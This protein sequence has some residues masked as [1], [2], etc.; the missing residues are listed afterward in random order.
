MLSFAH[1]RGLRLDH[2]LLSPA[3]AERCRACDIDRDA[4]KG[5]QPSDHAPVWAELHLE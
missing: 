2:L 5:E 4:R 3:L 1:N